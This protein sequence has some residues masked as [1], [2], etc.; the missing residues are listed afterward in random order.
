MYDKGYTEQST[1]FTFHKSDLQGKA[2]WIWIWK[3]GIHTQDT[4]FA[5]GGKVLFYASAIFL[6]MSGEKA[7]ESRICLW[8]W[9]SW[10]S[11]VLDDQRTDVFG[12]GSIRT[13]H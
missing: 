2:N 7:G 11:N 10:Q 4:I 3:A 12:G 13:V 6:E 1:H 5:L 9:A 8:K